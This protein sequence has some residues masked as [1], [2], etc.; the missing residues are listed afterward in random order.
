MDHNE[1]QRQGPTPES[2][3]GSYVGGQLARALRTATTHEDADTRRRAEL[4]LGRW[5]RVLDGLRDGS[6]HIGSR[7][8]VAGFPAWVTPEVVRG[9]FATG[10]ASAGGPLLPHE[11]ELARRAGVPADRRALFEYHLSDAGL[12]ELTTMLD[13]G[14]YEVTVPEEAAL[15]AVAWL[16]R[17]GER[18]AALELLEAIAPFSDRLRFAPRSTSA[19]APDPSTA[20]RR[21]V[22]EARADVARRQPK[23]AVEAMREALAVWN[24]FTDELLTLWLDVTDVDT[25]H[26]LTREPTPDWRLRGRE[27][28]NRYEKL[29]AEHRLCGK[30]RDPKQNQSILRTA[31][32][33]T[34]AGRPL[35][36]RRLGLVRHGIV[37]MVG[38]RGLPGS[39]EHTRLREWQAA[40]AKRP[41]HHDLARVVVRR[42]ADLPQDAGAT[43]TGAL[44]GPVTTAEQA[45]TGV[46]ADAEI[47]ETIRRLVERALSAP[48]G[49]LIERGIV[50]SAE[51]LAELV[52]Q[53]VASTTA[54][55]YPDASLRALM[56]AHHRA[57]G[58][59]RSLLLVNLHHQVRAEE[60]PWV[61]AVSGQ[62]ERGIEARGQ[63]RTVLTHVGELALT[64]FPATI[65]PNPMIARLSALADGAE[66]RMPWVEELAADI[67]MGRFSRKFLGAAVL[68]GGLLEGSL[69][70]RYFGIDYAAMAAWVNGDPDWRAYSDASVA[71][72][73]EMCRS[74]G[75]IGTERSVAANGVVIEQSQIL[76]THNLAALAG[77]VGAKPNWADLARRSFTAVCRLTA[78]TQ[79]NP[80]PLSTVKDAA[81]AWRQMV[82]HLS[83]C[84]EAERAEVESWLADETARH[85]HHVGRRLAPAL[86]GLRAVTAG[87]HFNARGTVDNDTGRRLVGW[88]T[89]RHWLLEPR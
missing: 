12:A 60:L 65:L 67:F 25:G 42:L 83:L 17:S 88:T 56:S 37:S 45:A 11:V 79:G 54:Q 64:G 44:L 34:L 13:G 73:G 74:R 24:P 76:T 36:A 48:I 81:Y 61:A 1:E 71:R 87:A 46:P 33:D 9:G 6:L 89:S 39:S 53:L 3:G 4:R 15:L 52:P 47:P 10:A 41:T 49:T 43:D 31:L 20:C 7:T 29:A 80:R 66:V 82:F 40:D 69:Y 75:D 30:H 58:R 62:R 85:P 26:V 28:L 8:P 50:P 27:L 23:H 18:A 21:T 78:R 19:P 59:R 35:D 57:F 38:R 84:G 68:A 2:A 70:E 22:G 63:A 32:A 16:A 5:R 51:V 14:H 55:A 77:P 72:F 86:R